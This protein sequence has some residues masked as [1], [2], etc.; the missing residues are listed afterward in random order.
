M[1]GV[2]LLRLH[3]WRCAEHAAVALQAV[4]DG[5]G[6][7]SSSS[8][9]SSGEDAGPIFKLLLARKVQE[10]QE[11]ALVALAKEQAEAEAVA[12]AARIAEQR[13]TV[14]GRCQ[15]LYAYDYIYIR[16]CNRVLLCY[17]IV[18]CA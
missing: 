7:G 14:A 2:L 10:Q 1:E 9:S 6:D 17:M 12:E 15:H 8:S 18:D 16:H 4:L 5:D 3:A 11:V 13:T